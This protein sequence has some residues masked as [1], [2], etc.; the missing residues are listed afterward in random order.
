MNAIVQGVLIVTLIVNIIGSGAA[1]YYY[2]NQGNGIQQ[3]NQMNFETNYDVTLDNNHCNSS[4]DCGN[5]KCQQDNGPNSP[6]HCICDS[7]YINYNGGTCNYYQKSTL[8]AFLWALLLPISGVNWFYLSCGSGGYITAG[9]F[10]VLVTSG[11]LIFCLP[12]LIYCIVLGASV[13]YIVDVIL[14]AASGMSDGNGVALS[15]W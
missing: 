7:R 13:W 11:L 8:V 9:V 1:V 3:N 2:Y 14:I 6:F 12:I 5:G 10:K 4:S 15:G